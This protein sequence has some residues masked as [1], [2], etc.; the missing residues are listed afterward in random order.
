MSHV[1]NDLTFG[2]PIT[3]EYRKQLKKLPKQFRQT[4]SP[5]Q[6]VEYMNE[7]SHEAFHHYMKV[8][9]M[10]YDI[11]G[12]SKNT[13]LQYQMVAQSQVMRYKED[14]ITE[15][16]FSY[17]ISPMA[18]H[19]STKSRAWY[20]FVTSL[21]AII[22]GTFTV[23]GFVDSILHKLLKPKFSIPGSVNK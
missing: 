3:R 14:E 15:A 21:C 22:G 19:I 10:H 20:D 23:L 9:S 13:V 17:D 18:V 8:V 16:K 5:L 12:F 7:R 2:P 1:V 6:S 4:D 11:G